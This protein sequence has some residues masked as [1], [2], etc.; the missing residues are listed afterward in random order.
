MPSSV[1]SFSVTKLRPGLQTM[2]LPS[3]IFMRGAQHTS[4]RGRTR[5]R[6][7]TVIG[8]RGC[9]QLVRMGG[10]CTRSTRRSIGS[11]AW[12]PPDGSAAS[13]STRSRT[14]RGSPAGAPTRST[15]AA[16]T[17]AAACWSA[18]AA[19]DSWS[20][21]TSRCR[22]C[23][24]RRSRGSASRR[25]SIRGPGNRA[26]RVPRSP[27]R[28][29]WRAVTSAAIT[30]SRAA[31]RW[32]PRLRRRGRR[33]PRRKSIATARSAATSAGSPA[34]CAD[35]SFPTS[36]KSRSPSGWPPAWRASARG[37]S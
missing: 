14:S 4:R 27:R 35:R 3:T 11:L 7:V 6:K 15:A 5:L 19:N 25:S 33:S 34:T 29:R 24:R 9:R 31:R 22:G 16:R 37:R 23:T 20:P 30:G 26:N 1:V 17:A 2:T 32:K 36:R 8:L 28:S 12:P 13:C 10:S 21:T 18:R